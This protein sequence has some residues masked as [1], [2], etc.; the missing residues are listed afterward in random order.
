[1]TKKYQKSKIRARKKIVTDS[2]NETLQIIWSI[3]GCTA[4]GNIWYDIDILEL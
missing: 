4:I 1:M 3:Q 2:D